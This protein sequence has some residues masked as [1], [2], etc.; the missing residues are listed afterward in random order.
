M[1][2]E[3]TETFASTTINSPETAW[4]TTLVRGGV[5]PHSGQRTQMAYLLP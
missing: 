4:G 3:A 1:T 2:T 5:G